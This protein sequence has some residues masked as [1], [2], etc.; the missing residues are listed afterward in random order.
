MLTRV[1]RVNDSCVYSHSH[2][3]IPIKKV[4]EETSSRGPKVCTLSLSI[5]FVS[6]SNST[7]QGDAIVLGWVHRSRDL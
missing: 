4:G 7:H 2:D 6:L 5:S 3:F 1:N